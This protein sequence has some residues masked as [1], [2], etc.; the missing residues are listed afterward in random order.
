V[1]LRG[2]FPSGQFIVIIGAIALSALLV[3]YVS[4]DRKEPAH[5]SLSE[6][7]SVLPDTDQ[8]GIKDW[9]ELLRGTDVHDPDT[10][11]D[12]SLDGAE[13]AVS[14]DP[15]KP[16]PDDAV[17]PTPGSTT[18][19]FSKVA[20]VSDNLTETVSQNSQ[21]PSPRTYSPPMWACTDKG[22]SPTPSLRSVPRLLQLK[23]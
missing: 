4:Y 15:L 19:D 3:A 5:I 7:G 2:Y 23:M 11:G 21:R 20:T 14:R 6:Q 1:N 13:T 16:G 10:D 17:T 8:D 18:P 22:W 9:E 12:G